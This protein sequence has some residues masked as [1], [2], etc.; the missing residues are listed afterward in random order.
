MH[1]NEYNPDIMLR[2]AYVHIYERTCI[3]SHWPTGMPIYQ[4][5][6]LSMDRHRIKRL[7]LLPSGLLSKQF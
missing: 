3:Y 2:L 1:I 7:M 6:R 5:T 4:Q